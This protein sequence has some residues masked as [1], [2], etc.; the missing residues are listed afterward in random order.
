MKVTSIFG[1]VGL[2][3]AILAAFAV[4]LFGTMRLSLYN[5]TVKVPDIVGKDRVTAESELAGIG[6][7]LTARLTRYVP[8]KQPN[9]ILDQTPHPGETVKKG[10]PIAVIVARGPKEGEVP[11]E[12]ANTDE[13]ETTNENG[14]ANSS[15]SNNSNGKPAVVRKKVDNKNANAGNKSGNKNANANTNNK[16]ANANSVN[17][18]ANANAANGNK[19]ANVNAVNK[20]ANVSKGVNANGGNRNRRATPEP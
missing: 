10:L 13:E 15:G 14:N 12:N 18:N 1:K 7:K 2:L 4:G 9:T 16:N 6:L 17:K 20:N 5:P 11:D 8:D 3:L 19:N